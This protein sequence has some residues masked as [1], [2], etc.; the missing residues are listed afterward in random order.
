[1]TIALA[2][3]LMTL[4][5]AGQ[6]ARKYI[7]HTSK[8]VLGCT[9]DHRAVLVGAVTSSARPFRLA[10]QS[11]GSTLIALDGKPT[12]YLS[13]GTND[14]WST[15]FLTDSTDSRARYTLE[16]QGSYTLLRNKKTGR[17]LG[18]DSNNTGAN[19]F[20]DKSGTDIKHK[21]MLSDAA[22]VA[23]SVDTVSYVVSPTSRRQ[24]L[25]GW[26]V[27]LCWWA[28]MCGKWDDSKINELVRWLVSQ[29]GLNMKVFRYN[30]GGGDDPNWTHCEKHHMGKGKGLRAEME[31]FQD[32]HGGAYHWERDAAQRKIMLKI[33]EMRPDAVFEA[34]SNSAPWWMTVSGCVGGNTSGSKDNLKPEYYKDFAHYLV[35]VCKHY[36]DEYGIEFKTLEPFNEPLSDYWHSSG[37]QEGCHFDAKSQANFLKVLEPIL[38]ES[39]LR[40]VI[41]A[42]DETNTTHSKQAWNTYEQN[43]VLNLIKQWN[44]HT[45]TANN[46]ERAQIGALARAAGKQVWMSESGSGGDGIGGNLAMSQRL[47]DDMRYLAPS[48]WCDWQYGEEFGDQWCL[49]STSFSDQTYKRVKNYYVRAQVTRYIK[50]G[51]S[52]VSSTCDQSLC[53]VNPTGDSLVVV[54]QNNDTKKVHRLSIPGARIKGLCTMYRTSSNESTARLRS[55]EKL[56]DS[57]LQVA[58]PSQ[59]ITTLIIPI[60]PTSEKRP[61]LADGDTYLIVPQANNQVAAKAQKDKVVLADADANDPDQCWTLKQSNDGKWW[62]ET[63]SGRQADYNSGYYLKPSTTARITYELVPVDGLHYRIKVPG[64]TKCWDM[65]Q[66]KTQAGT[67]IGTWDYG[68]SAAAHHRQWQLIRIG[69]NKTMVPDAIKKPG[70]TSSG[71]NAVYSLQGMRLPDTQRGINIIS[72]P[73]GHIV[74]MCK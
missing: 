4:A 57:T 3:S 65:E 61:M 59:S 49:V 74:K 45:Y 68:T 25:E 37:S 31:G 55:Y 47:M 34:F 10:K 11:D 9:S 2:C 16:T 7:V 28:N 22:Q 23:V 19:V 17:Y 5:A 38:R 43:S 36:R 51:Y 13:L 41:S 1:M 63:A 54:M 6:N 71:K 32:K 8:N 30:I 24:T 50:P 18:T 15:F 67:A 58:L 42:S 69:S 62:L 20:S 52:I 66:E 64:S 56:N 21:W 44:T 73:D 48:V 70:A 27:S 39:G 29:D 33:K 53:A 12:L 35:D 60:R 26:G 14:N 72:R 40:T 46:Y